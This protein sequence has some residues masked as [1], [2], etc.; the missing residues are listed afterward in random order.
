MGVSDLISGMR[1]RGEL[2]KEMQ[3]Q[4]DA[5]TKVETRKLSADE[6]ALNKVLE[7]ERQ[8]RIREELA[9][10]TKREEREYW[11]KDVISQPNLF[12]N[13]NGNSLLKWGG[14]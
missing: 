3:A 13:K 11:H 7:Q 8:K 6:R 4:D 10:R 12:G 2:F 1:R 14:N 9:R 5:A